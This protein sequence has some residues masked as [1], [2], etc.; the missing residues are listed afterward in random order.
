MN[1]SIIETLLEERIGLY[2]EAIGHETIEKSIR[3]RMEH[4]GIPLIED[5]YRYLL[6]S[7]DEWEELIESIVVPET[8]FFR[9]VESFAFLG[10]YV[11]TEWLLKNRHRVMRILSIPCSTGEEPYSIAITLLDAGLTPGRFHID[12][13]DISKKA[14]EKAKAGIYGRESFRRMNP[15]LVKRYFL[16]TEDK[17]ELHGFVKESVDF[18]RGNVLE[19]SVFDENKSYDVIF[20]RN[21]LIY[22]SSSARQKTV[23]MIEKMLTVAGLLFVGHVE[24]PLINRPSFEW[25]REPSVFASRKLNN[26]SPPPSLP[27]KW[28]PVERDKEKREPPRKK[29]VER[30]IILPSSEPDAEVM[31]PPVEETPVSKNDDAGADNDTTLEKAQH[32]ADQG[33]LFEALQK[34]EKIISEDSLNIHAYFLMGVICHALGDNTHAEEYFN[35]AIYLNPNHYE[36]LSYLAIIEEQQGNRDKAARLRSRAQRIGN[37]ED[38]N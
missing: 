28:M 10:R 3:R 38:G 27:P 18:I 24:R 31:I 23:R 21:L 33:E 7:Y 8:W 12:A 25:I 2:A 1:Q 11:V 26:V 29:S 30:P 5:Y 6:T 34:C 37:R 4:L 19:N 13:V 17:Y 16:G 15:V 32:L 22:F 14:I 9:N 20:C 36:A 35:K